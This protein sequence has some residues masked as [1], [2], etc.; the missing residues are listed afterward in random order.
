[1]ILQHKILNRATLQ[2]VVL[3]IMTGCNGI[4]GGI[5]D[6]PEV[7]YGVAP[8]ADS[9]FGTLTVSQSGVSTIKVNATEYDR[10]IYLDLHNRTADTVMIATEEHDAPALWDIAL[11]RYDAKTSGAE[12][13]RTPYTTIEQLTTSRTL[14]QGTWHGD[15]W[16]TDR[17]I[18]DLTHMIQGV[19]IYTPTYLNTELSS[20][21]DVDLSTMPP[22][23]TSSNCVYLVKFADGTM[24]AMRLANY[25]NASRVKG[26][27]TIEFI[28]PL[29][30]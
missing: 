23:Y 27:L 19:L 1:M 15:I 26:H 16:T 22:I 13:M 14:P 24:A 29:T 10:W 12:V 28:Y 18:L 7:E 2:L 6:D 17:V 9:V 4:F 5:Y 20:W 3:I 25:A 8:G 30:L 11:H 21:L